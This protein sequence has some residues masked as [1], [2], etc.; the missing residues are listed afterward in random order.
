MAEA[1]ETSSRTVD[2]VVVGGG[3][4]GLA[5]AWRLAQR[6]STVTLVDDD[7]AGGASR[8]AAG[9]LAPVT[10]AH[11]GEEALTAL[12]LESAPRWPAFAADGEAAGGAPGGYRTGGAPASGPWASP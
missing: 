9:M 12:N 3:V 10:E 2:A 5:V 11:F 6:G 1:P 8:A 7:P 4:I